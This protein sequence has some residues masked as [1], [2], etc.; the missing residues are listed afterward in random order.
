MRKLKRTHLL[1]VAVT[2]TI[3][4]TTSVISAQKL[5]KRIVI[6][7]TARGT[8]TQM[9]RQASIDLRIEALTSP[10]ERAGLLE[11]FQQKGN[12]GLVNALDK[13]RAKGRM[14]VTGTL[15]YDVN[16][17]WVFKQPDGS[18][19]L[20]MVTDRPLLFGEVY[21]DTRSRDYELAGVEIHISKDRRKSTGKLYPA[22]RLK[23]NKKGV[24][25]LQLYQNPWELVNI[26]KR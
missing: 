22:C 3:L 26:Q 9:G 16:Y 6:Q 5:P 18:M 1:T 21:A 23:V 2:S 12:E 7:A 17:V 10:E 14:A 15:G 19:L 24:V 8:S 13:M 4:L 25:E 11:A 20:R